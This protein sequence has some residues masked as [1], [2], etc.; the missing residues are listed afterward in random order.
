MIWRDLLGNNIL[1]SAVLSWTLAQVIKFLVQL[2]RHRRI[3][4]RMLVAP[5]GMPSGHSATMMALTT[6]VGL[7][8]GFGS[9]AFAIAFVMS[10]IVM[11]DAT[12]IRRSA[13]KQAAV[14]NRVVDRLVQSG[15][16]KSQLSNEEL[17]EIL[18][19]TPVQVIVGAAMGIAIALVFHLRAIFSA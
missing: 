1:W 17:K 13:G 16:E 19:H 10:M 18:G 3:D 5:G 2:L 8:S 14:L 7:D 4:F 15:H 11:Y 9:A 12:G 6:S